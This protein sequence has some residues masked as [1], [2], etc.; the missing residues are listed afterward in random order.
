MGKIVRFDGKDKWYKMALAGKDDDGNSF[1][2]FRCQVPAEMPLLH[3]LD[4]MAE[5]MRVIVIRDEEELEDSVLSIVD[6]LLDALQMTLQ[7][8][9]GFR[10]EPQ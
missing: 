7:N 2:Y 1:D 5:A 4:T 3:R 8:A 10:G 6:C 9:P